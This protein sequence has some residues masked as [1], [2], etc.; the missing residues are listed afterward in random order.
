MH[1]FYPFII[2]ITLILL[3]AF[4]IQNFFKDKKT[5][6]PSEEKQLNHPL[7]IAALK[8]RNYQGSD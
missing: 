6:S 2:I 4:F 1:K 8:E 7:S 3:A 5:N